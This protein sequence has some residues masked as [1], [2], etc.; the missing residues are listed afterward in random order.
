MK[1]LPKIGTKAH[2]ELK[3]KEQIE[4]LNDIVK[5][6]LGPSEKWG[7]GVIAIKDIKTGTKLYMDAMPNMFDL[8][9]KKFNEL[10]KEVGDIVLRHFPQIING[11]H[12]MYPVAKFLAYVNHSEDPNYDAKEDKTLTF[13]AKGE[14][15]TEDFRQIKDYKKI[16]KWLK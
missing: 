9:F 3:Y 7:I 16:F 1:K 14:E 2:K 5:F 6:K 4:I 12:F 10:D 11:S 13:I 8:P 15:I